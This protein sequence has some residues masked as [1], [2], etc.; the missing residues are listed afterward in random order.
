MKRYKIAVCLSGQSRTW[1]ECV[2][3]LK[4]FY[5]DEDHDYYFFGHT[6]DQNE[7]KASCLAH[8]IVEGLNAQ[9]L[10][11]AMDNEIGFTKLMVSPALD[12]FAAMHPD[13]KQFPYEAR[14]G[15]EDVALHV[16]PWSWVSLFKSLM[17]ANSL[18]TEYEMENDMKFDLVV[19]ARFDLAYKPGTRFKDKIPGVFQH[20]FPNTLYCSPSHFPDE[21]FLPA[22]NDLF[23]FG[24]SEVMDLVDSFYRSHHNG[25]FWKIIGADYYDSC[26]KQA[27]PNVLLWKWMSVKNVMPYAISAHD[28][29]IVRRGY[30]TGNWP[31]DYEAYQESYSNPS[32]HQK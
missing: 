9:L 10:H 21:M 32:F 20:S 27:G 31:E 18:K 15:I 17:L 1:E 8:P 28:M 2:Q 11:E 7:W 23:Y 22:I 3:S 26:Y 4:E 29:V 5:N 16:K 14:T 30:G 13:N 12:P 25:N 24:S 6:W 19:R